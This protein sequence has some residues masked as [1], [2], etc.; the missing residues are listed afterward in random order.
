MKR[1]GVKPNA[2]EK[3]HM[4]RL[5]EMACLA[6]K[7]RPVHVHHLLRSPH[8]RRRRD[9]MATVPLCPTCHT[10]QGSVHHH[11]DERLFFELWGRDDVYTWALEQ[12]NESVRLSHA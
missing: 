1:K 7:Q 10:G 5:A 11:G 3:L 9:H 12:A 8:A 2:L 4:A 6:C